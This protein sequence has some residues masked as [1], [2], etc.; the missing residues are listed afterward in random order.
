MLFNCIYRQCRQVQSILVKQ[1][2][3]GRGN[4]AGEKE[5]RGN[6]RRQELQ[7]AGEKLPME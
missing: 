5:L 3:V 7:V 4:F 2:R 6:M 1:P